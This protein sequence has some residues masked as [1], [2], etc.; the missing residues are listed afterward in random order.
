M[1]ARFPLRIAALLVAP[2]CL[3]AAERPERP[4]SDASA[5][6]STQRQ[7]IVISVKRLDVERLAD[8]VKQVLHHQATEGSP[9]PGLVHDIGSRALIITGTEEQLDRLRAL[10][11]GLDAQAAEASE[12][13]VVESSVFQAEL[14]QIELPREQVSNL[15]VSD[16]HARAATATDMHAALSELGDVDVLYRFDQ[17]VRLQPT[18]GRQDAKTFSI[19]SQTP[20]IRSKHVS[21]SG[22]VN[23]QVEYEKIG[24]I[25]QLSGSWHEQRHGAAQVHLELSGLT[26]SAVTVSEGINAPVFRD[27]VQLHDGPITAGKPII[28]LSID[29]SRAG[30]TATAYVT[31]MQFDVAS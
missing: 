9:P 2:A 28:L 29:G 6:V 14:Y 19:K 17:V 23:R 3:F 13:H 8:I 11:A 7:T 21:D 25:I 12:T 27:I 5:Q 26:D 24:C 18:S 30:N 1:Y 22:Q 4:P 16:L 15:S 31:R 20:F 10:V